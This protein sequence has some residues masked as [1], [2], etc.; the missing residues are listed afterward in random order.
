MGGTER[1]F[2]RVKIPAA[3]RVSV[4]Q[5]VEVE[6]WTLLIK[7]IGEPTCSVQK[8]FQYPCASMESQWNLNGMGALF[9]RN[10]DGSLKFLVWLNIP[11]S[12]DR[13]VH[14]GW[15]SL[16]AKRTQFIKINSTL[17]SQCH[18]SSSVAVASPRGESRGPLGDPGAKDLAER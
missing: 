18:S 14:W 10:F 15:C 6:I 1:I 8:N 16:H 9:F 13:V 5:K 12:R 11:Q 3:M 17:F 7:I 4:E 2:R